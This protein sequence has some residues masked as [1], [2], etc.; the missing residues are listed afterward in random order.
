MKRPDI[1]EN[2][3]LIQ[4]FYPHLAS[5]FEKHKGIKLHKLPAVYI[6]HAIESPFIKIG[7]S[8]NLKSRISNIQSGC[9]FRL[10]IYNV[11][12]TPICEEIEDYLHKILF[13]CNQHGEWFKPGNDEIDFLID[14]FAKTNSHIREVHNALL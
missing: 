9:P 7:I 10:S 4:P 3:P 6:L 5:D 12:R 11:I 13:H 14:F 2:T 8:T 1:G